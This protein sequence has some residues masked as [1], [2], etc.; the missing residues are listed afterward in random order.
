MTNE[1][2]LPYSRRVYHS[3]LLYPDN[4]KKIKKLP[5]GVGETGRRGRRLDIYPHTKCKSAPLSQCYAVPP[6]PR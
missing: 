4:P 3:F 5:N 2:L 6:C 1:T